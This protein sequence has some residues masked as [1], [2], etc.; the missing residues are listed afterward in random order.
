[1]KL[2]TTGCSFAGPTSHPPIEEESWGI[3]LAKILNL[4][5]CVEGNGDGWLNL[6]LGGCSLDYISR[7]IIDQ[8]IPNLDKDLVVV[9]G[10]TSIQRW[11]HF[12]DELG[13]CQ[14]NT[15]EPYHYGAQAFW[16]ST[17]TSDR[18]YKQHL[19][20]H[21]L[22]QEHMRKLNMIITLAGFLKSHNIKYVFFNAFEPLDGWKKGTGYY[23]KSETGEDCP[24]LNKLTDYVR[25]NVNFL[26]QLQI[27]IGAK[28]GYE[29][30][31]RIGDFDGDDKSYP[32][33]KKEYFTHDGWHPSLVAHKEW[34]KILYDA[35]MSES[36]C[37][38]NKKY[39]IK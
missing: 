22:F 30:R 29:E 5:E 24:V 28:E 15:N 18:E 13:K 37:H 2:I 25:Q 36:V 11:E 27:E 14:A 31:V 12:T 19:L 8:V 7:G 38:L 10:W 4:E 6:G 1:M 35:I 32:Y 21:T 23:D 9:V 26:E 39:G 17:L 16:K 20:N 33:T 3:Q 34:S